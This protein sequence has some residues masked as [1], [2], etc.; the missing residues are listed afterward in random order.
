MITPLPLILDTAPTK[1]L[2]RH[3]GTSIALQHSDSFIATHGLHGV[4]N[5]SLGEW[6][7]LCRR[8]STTIHALHF[9]VKA[10][11]RLL[12]GCLTFAMMQ[13][14]QPMY[15]MKDQSMNEL[16]LGLS[17]IGRSPIHSLSHVLAHSITLAHR[18]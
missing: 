8:Q 9:F 3:Y 1:H 2:F 14:I 16:E 12:D 6:W 4:K 10:C 18:I 11:Y 13:V 5:P 17:P 15:D 7:D